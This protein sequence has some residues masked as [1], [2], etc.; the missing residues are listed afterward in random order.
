MNETLSLL[1]VSVE[2][3]TRVATWRSD[4]KLDAAARDILLALSV[5]VD[6]VVADLEKKLAAA[7]GKPTQR[8]Y[9]EPL[10]LRAKTMAARLRSNATITERSPQNPAAALLEIAR[11][12]L[13]GKDHIYVTPDIPEGKRRGAEKKFL[14]DL[15]HDEQL[16]ALIDLTVFGRATDGVAILDHRFIHRFLGDPISIAYAEIHGVFSDRRFVTVNDHRLDLLTAE[17]AAAFEDFLRGVRQAGLG[18]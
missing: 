4:G 16:I 13:I 1:D 3:C 10:L 2:L 17:V 8:D 11:E 12:R 5:R 9:L 15:G 18:R 7:R 6:A 14:K